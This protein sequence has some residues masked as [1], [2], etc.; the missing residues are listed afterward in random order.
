M[1][2]LQSTDSE[3]NGLKTVIR[4]HRSPRFSTM[5]RGVLFTQQQMFP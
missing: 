2:E 5:K 4:N 3:N 1:L